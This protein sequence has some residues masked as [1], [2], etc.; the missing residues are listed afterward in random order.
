MAKSIDACCPC[1]MVAPWYGCAGMNWKPFEKRRSHERECKCISS[2][3]DA[4]DCYW[5]G[6]ELFAGQWKERAQ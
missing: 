5:P 1:P 6:H 4:I 2:R 3:P